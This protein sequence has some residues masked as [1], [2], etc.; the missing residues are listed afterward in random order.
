M[1]SVNVMDHFRNWALIGAA[2]QIELV[3]KSV[4]LHWGKGVG[5]D[6]HRISAK[7]FGVDGVLRG[8][9]FLRRH[10]EG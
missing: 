3:T 6:T 10:T 5:R 2:I 7:R 1:V 9:R 8:P 4:V